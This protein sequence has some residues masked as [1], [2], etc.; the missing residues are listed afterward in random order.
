MQQQQT[1]ASAAQPSGAGMNCTYARPSSCAPPEDYIT[2][3]LDGRWHFCGCPFFQ[4]WLTLCTSEPSCE[5]E[6]PAAS[7][8]CARRPRR[9][10]GWWLP[11]CA[12]S[13]SD[14]PIV[15]PVKIDSVA[16]ERDL[17]PSPGM[18]GS[19]S[20]LLM[21]SSE[22]VPCGSSRLLGEC[23]LVFTRQ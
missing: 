11:C 18:G 4:S 13:S 14:T 6:A 16:D 7:R 5:A 20:S 17:G 1:S 9:A 21:I 3:C 12:V 23:L 19:L 2:W 8:C 15:Q 10:P 22:S